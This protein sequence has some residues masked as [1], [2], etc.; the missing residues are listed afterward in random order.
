MWNIPPPLRL[1]SVYTEGQLCSHLQ[2]HGQVKLSNLSACLA[3]KS[4]ICEVVLHMLAMFWMWFT[5]VH[6]QRR[7]LQSG[8]D[9]GYWGLWV[10]R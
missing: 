3:L 1:T 4:V 6:G 7:S 2:V 9:K 8:K 10:G 5:E